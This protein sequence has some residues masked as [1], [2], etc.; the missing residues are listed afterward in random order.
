MN[1]KKRKQWR[2]APWYFVLE[3]CKDPPPPTHTYTL[4]N[5]LMPGIWKVTF[6]GKHFA[7][8]I[9]LRTLRWGDYPGCGGPGLNTVTSVL[10]AGR[11]GRGRFQPREEKTL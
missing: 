1:I 2:I 3:F 7:N 9:K 5:V 8:V 6:C 11:S 4:H 10:M